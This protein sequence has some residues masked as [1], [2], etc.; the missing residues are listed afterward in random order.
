MSGHENGG[1]SAEND[2]ALIEG[3]CEVMHDAYDRH[4]V[5][6]LTAYVAGV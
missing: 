3:A 4:G 2:A 6:F 5:H 1:Q